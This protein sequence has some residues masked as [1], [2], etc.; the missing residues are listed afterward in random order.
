MRSRLVLLAYA[1]TAFAV[2]LSNDPTGGT[3]NVKFVDD[4]E[5]D[6]VAE[7]IGT[8]YND[9]PS[10]TNDEL[11]PIAGNP[12][13]SMPSSS[14]QPFGSESFG[15]KPWGSDDRFGTQPLGSKSPGSLQTPDKAHTSTVG[16]PS[17]NEEGKWKCPEKQSPF[18]CNGRSL[19]SGVRTGC[20]ACTS[21][22]SQSAVMRNVALRASSH[23][24]RLSTKTPPISSKYFITD[25]D[26]LLGSKKMVKCFMQLSSFCCDFV[27]VSCI[28]SSPQ[29]R[30][31]L[32]GGGEAVC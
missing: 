31:K 14:F 29:P 20:S 28:F 22:L 12:P 5:I 9:V 17:L 4:Y 13:D 21:P 6:G 15:S 10:T 3:G 19:G 24:P 32:A 1:S 25:A 27:F 30:L 16:P 2:P 7:S 23:R 11:S 26:Y 8:Q 18:C